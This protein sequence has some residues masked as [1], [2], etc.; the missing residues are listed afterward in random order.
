MLGLG[1][2]VVG[3]R[4]DLHAAVPVE[5][6]PQPD[7]VQLELGELEP[8][9]PVVGRGLVLSGPVHAEDDVVHVGTRRGHDASP[10]AK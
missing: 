5:E 4:D 7:V 1:A 3:G 9:V 8:E 6:H 10:V 2:G